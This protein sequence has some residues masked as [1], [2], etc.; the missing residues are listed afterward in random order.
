MKILLAVDGSKY[1]DAA[2]EEVATR[3]WPEDTELV[4]LSAVDPPAVPS[5][6]PWVTLPSYFVDVEK[7]AQERAYNVVRSARERIQAGKN[8]ML[9]ISSTTPIG[10]AKQVILNQVE[11]LKP[12]LVVVGSHGYGAWDRF[13]LGSV[14]HSVSLHAPCSVEI[15]RRNDAAEAI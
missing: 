3:P 4:I 1:S 15:V 2:V 14:S 9:R 12:D 6:E 5:M 11:S 13:L 7:A 10:W 8:K